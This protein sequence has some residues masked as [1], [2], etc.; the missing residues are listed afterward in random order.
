MTFSFNTYS[1]SY[2]FRTFY[3]STFSI[4]S[5]PFF[6]FFFRYF[7]KFSL[8]NLI[9]AKKITARKEQLER[10]RE[11][12]KERRRRIRE[13]PELRQKEKEKEHA[14]YLKKKEKKQVLSISQMS[15]RSK[16]TQRKKW[17]IN[18]RNSRDRKKQ[19]QLLIENTPPGSDDEEI[20]Q[21]PAIPPSIPSSASRSEQYKKIRDRNKKMRSRKFAK[22]EQLIKKLK[23]KVERYKKKLQRNRKI[24]TKTVDELSVEERADNIIQSGINEIRTNLILG[25]ALKKQLAKNY[26]NLRKQKDK[27]FLTQCIGGK[28]LKKYKLLSRC[29]KFCNNRKLP[30]IDLNFNR[31]TRKDIKLQ[32][33]I[34]NFLEEDEHSRMCPGKKEVI[35]KNGLELQKRYLNE[36]LKNLH[37]KFISKYNRQISY[38]LFCKSCP[39]WIKRMNVA[40]RETCKCI[41]HSNMEFMIQALAKYN[42]IQETCTKDVINSMCCSKSVKCLLRLCEECV[43]RTP[44]INNILIDINVFYF[45]WITQ[46]TKYTCPKTNKEKTCKKI[47][48]ENKAI[49][50]RVLIEE[51]KETLTN[52][53]SHEGKILHQYIAIRELKSKLKYNEAIIHMD[54]S[55]NYNVK[56]FE[57]IQSFHFG[58]SRKQI[59]LHTVVVYLKIEDD[60]KCK[61]FCTISDS[62]LHNVAA[63]WAHLYPILKSLPDN[64]NVFHFLS[65]S[66]ATQYRN[67]C[68]FYFLRNH[69]K[70]IYPINYFTWNYSETGHGKGAPDGIGGVCKR[71]AD[72]EVAN[73]KD[74]PDITVLLSVLQEKCLNIQFY[75]INTSDIEE[76]SKLIFSEKIIPFKGTMQVHQV[77]CGENNELFMRKLSCFDCKHYCEH[78]NIGTLN[79]AENSNNEFTCFPNQTESNSRL[80]Y[81]DV[82]LTPSSK[83]SSSSCATPTTEKIECGTFLLV[84]FPGQRGKTYK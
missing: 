2:I 24:K 27:L 18:Q 57:E 66:P 78:F 69:L 55:E 68:M 74:I 83:S 76:M 73:G 7:L 46:L 61:S 67:K 6:E 82:Y 41:T 11:A 19:L 64:I 63:I 16:K 36:T 59:T 9:M 1:I 54:F 71:I 60:I 38:S 49:Q 12:E 56:Y 14:R 62:L 28:I 32:N 70:E 43:N 72:R 20:F 26:R 25:E 42:A 39:Y 40:Q 34:K 51:Y 47:V 3:N 75:Q 58:G 50:L 5:L 52:F 79:Y 77:A 29:R 8:T 17:R 4:N 33:D 80:R 35:K 81:E 44:E 45:K 65:D 84:Q 13:D 10:K 21:H 23:T 22:Q 53:L 15:A 37:E 48:K 30:K 31:K